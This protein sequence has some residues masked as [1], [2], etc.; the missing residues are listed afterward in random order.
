MVALGPIHSWQPARGPVTTW[1]ASSAA[2]DTARQAPL[3]ELPPSFQQ[4]G[5]LRGAFY[6]KQLGRQ[7]PRLMVVAWDMPG[8]CDIA[9]MT[10]AIN[11]HVRRHNTYH[12]AFEV[13]NGAIVRRTL[14]DPNTIEFE[15]HSFG[16]MDVEQVRE[17][18]LTTTPGTLDWDC[19]TFGV[20][21]D[22]DHFTFYASVDHLHI[23]AISAGVIFVDIHLMYQNLTQGQPV[24]A[25]E[26]VGYR[27][28]AERQ[29]E[30]VAGMTLSS[31]EIKDWIEFGRDTDGDWPSFPLPLG[32]TW[33]SPLGDFVTVELLDEDNTNA[34]DTACREA[35][36]R[37]SGGVLACAALAEHQL[38]GNSTYHGFT[39]SDTRSG[40]TEAM[41][42]GWFASLFP[43]TVAIGDGDFA[44]AARAAQASFDANRYLANVPFERAL[45]LAPADELGITLPTRQ[46]MMASFLDFR[47]IPVADLWLQTN[48]GIY[49]DNFSHGGINMWI[50][51]HAARTTVTISFPDNDVARKSVHRYIAALSQQFA[52]VAKITADWIDELAHHANSSAACAVC[53]GGRS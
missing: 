8:Q 42:V 41:S 46:S 36:A 3:G 51:R 38:T 10:E 29:R 39:P 7:L 4:T 9:L 43:V 16:T 18:A 33:E 12:S 52:A 32:D 22:A 27:D 25:P 48:F 2:R 35:G 53:V 24:A 6:G 13:E 45:Q 5:H 26:V 19:F 15:P 14:E 21:Q 40:G 50:N 31:P 20:I 11:A 28:Y 17:H 23:D 1:I 37:F 49:G 34:F 30:Q 47:K 44:G